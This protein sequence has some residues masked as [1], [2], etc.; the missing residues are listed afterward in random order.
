LPSPSHGLN[1][2][3]WRDTHALAWTLSLTMQ[4][5]L[6][7]LLGVSSDFDDACRSI[8][9]PFAS[10]THARPNSDRMGEAAASAA[11]Q[12]RDAPA[13]QAACSHRQPQP[14]QQ[15]HAASASPGTFASA[16]SAA[17]DCAPS[18]SS[19]FRTPPKTTSNSA[20]PSHLQVDVKVVAGQAETAEHSEASAAKRRKVAS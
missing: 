3:E 10:P 11:R 2:F 9:L 20:L 7:A 14:P 15:P 4:A 19:P 13:S 5:R 18:P 17:A 8:L 12:P 16:P 6:A 1:S